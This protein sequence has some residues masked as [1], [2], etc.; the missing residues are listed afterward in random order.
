MTHTLGTLSH[1]YSPLSSPTESSKNGEA[2]Q[3]LKK[4]QKLAHTYTRELL[5]N[6]KKQLSRI[7][8]AD[9]IKKVMREHPGAI[10]YIHH[11]GGIYP[12][13]HLEL[14]FLNEDDPTIDSLPT[15]FVFLR[16]EIT[17]VDDLKQPVP[18]AQNY[19]RLNPETTSP[20]FLRGHIENFVRKDRPRS[21]FGFFIPNDVFETAPKL[22]RNLPVGVHHFWLDFC[23]SFTPNLVRGVET[24]LCAL[25]E[26][27]TALKGFTCSTTYNIPRGPKTRHED[28]KPLLVPLERCLKKAKTQML[29]P[30]KSEKTPRLNRSLFQSPEWKEVHRLWVKR[31]KHLAPSLSNA[32]LLM[33]YCNGSSRMVVISL[34]L[35]GETKPI[36]L[37]ELLEKHKPHLAALLTPTKPTKSTKPKSTK[38]T[39]ATE[40]EQSLKTAKPVSISRTPALL[41]P[42]SLPPASPQTYAQ[43]YSYS[44]PTPYHPSYYTAR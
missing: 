16:Y 32:Q 14:Q 43:A 35:S 39:K 8:V 28:T 19:K 34:H 10:H 44:Y 30:P 7:L 12:D 21:K 4:P 37:P 20:K 13:P 36:A 11:F 1:T 29:N 9:N 2:P 5:E 24:L 31:A 18:V 6:P 15:N 27:P 38:S 41:A 33:P 3:N 42:Q 25:E 40:V 17:T 22:I 23:G 26:S